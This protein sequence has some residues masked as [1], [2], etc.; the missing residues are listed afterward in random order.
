MYTYFGMSV[1]LLVC[2]HLA[3]INRWKRLIASYENPDTIYVMRAMVI[4]QETNIFI[5][6][7]LGDLV[8]ICFIGR[9]LKNGYAL[10]MATVI[11]DLYMDTLTVGIAFLSLYV[12]GIHKNEITMVTWGYIFLSALIILLTVLVF[13]CKKHI[14]KI[15]QVFASIFN[16][17]VELQ[18][19]YVTYATFACFKNIFKKI[20]LKKLAWL[21]VVMWGSYFLSYEMFARFMQ[22]QGYDFVLTDVFRTIFSSIGFSIFLKSPLFLMYLLVPLLVLGCYAFIR[23]PQIISESYYHLLPQLSENEKLAFL[24]IYFGNEEEKEYLNLY[25]NINRDI[26]VIQ[27]YSSGS[28]ATT[29]LCMNNTRTFYR[30]YAIAKDAIKLEKQIAWLEK[31]METLPVAHVLNKASGENYCYYDME[32]KPEAVGFF[33]YIHTMPVEKSWKILQSVLETLGEIYNHTYATADKKTVKEYINEKVVHNIDICLNRG[34]KWLKGLVEYDTLCINGINYPNLQHYKKMLSEENLLD[35]F[36][37]EN[38]SE[39]HGDLTI[40]NIVCLQNI[41]NTWYLIDPNTG[42]LHESAFLDYAKLL[43]SLHGGYEFLMM[44]KDVSI[45]GNV[46]N[47]LCAKSSAYSKLY[48]EYKKYLYKHFSRE[49]VTSI[50]I[51]EAIHWLR[52]MPYK[53]KK[54]PKRAVIFYAE[55]CI[56]LSDIEHLIFEERE[57]T[58]E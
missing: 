45:H 26:S 58:R 36:L 21:T 38:Y 48:E 11:A 10:S 19:L 40:E 6:W 23:K 27:D 51:H 29:M 47:F 1:L 34:G 24:E 57:N 54:D 14:K 56:I 22:W 5:P 3:K 52:L 35:R 16:S 17:K 13:F 25:L 43:Q 28:N 31:H 33:Q 30:K 8:R 32:Y 7:R 2:G 18:I 12:F 41:S 46:V 49:K 53:I 9:H 15:I 4:G 20:N 39:I 55:M 42:N 44:V 50:Y 37:E